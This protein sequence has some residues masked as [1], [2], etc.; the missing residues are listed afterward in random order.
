MKYQIRA[1]SSRETFPLRNNEH[2]ILPLFIAQMD[3]INGSTTSKNPLYTPL[4]TPVT[5]IIKMETSASESDIS[6]SIIAMKNGKNIGISGSGMIIPG[7]TGILRTNGIDCYDAFGRITICN[8]SEKE[9]LDYFYD[10]S[11]R[12][13]TFLSSDITDPYLLVYNAGSDANISLE[14]NTP[15]ALPKLEVMT[16]V[17]KGNALQS[18]RFQE[19]KTRYYDALK[20]GIYNSGL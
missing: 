13:D 8:G 15:F 4:T 10:E 19:D 3:P 1:H 6:W 5:S 12:I 16:E 7:K 11:I 2:L 14:T 20:Y 17:R 18:I 9:A